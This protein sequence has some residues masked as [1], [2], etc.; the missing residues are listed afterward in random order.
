MN[1]YDKLM[2]SLYCTLAFLVVFFPGKHF[3]ASIFIHY[4]SAFKM[5]SIQVLFN[6]ISLYITTL[7]DSL[8]CTVSELYKTI[9]SKDP[10]GLSKCM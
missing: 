8:I 9:N 2:R 3:I 1:K 10:S 4:C 6:S 5:A 7:T